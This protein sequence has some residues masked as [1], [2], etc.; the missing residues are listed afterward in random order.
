MSI[1]YIYKRNQTNKFTDKTII[2]SYLYEI[3]IKFK[4]EKKKS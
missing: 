2:K 4:N 3:T 1:Y